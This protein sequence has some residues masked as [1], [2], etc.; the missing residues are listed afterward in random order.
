MN[1]FVKWAGGKHQILNELKSYLPKK[2]N[3]YYEP[4]I[5]G[6][7]LLFE[8]K[9]TQATINDYNPQL[10]NVYYQ[11]QDSPKL[12][13]ERISKMQNKYNKLKTLED[14]KDYYYKLRSQYN[15]LVAHP[16]KDPEGIETATLFIVLN[17]LGFNGLYR[18]NSNGE[19]NVPWNQKDKLNAYDENNISEI[20]KYLENVEILNGDFEEACKTAKK[21][22]LVYFDPPYDSDVETFTDYTKV[23]FGK[24]E[25]VRLAEC[26]KKLDKKGVKVMLS[27]HN[28]KLINE[29]YKDY[30][31][32]V[33]EA[34]RNINSNGTGRGKVEE[35]IITNYEN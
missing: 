31:I 1:P 16:E 2:Y 13:I 33:I 4:F 28:T 20:N 5:G 9:P 3:H 6:G 12:L 8:L 25:Q 29:L 17:K 26:F 27:N 19:F 14:K 32:H 21:D 24:D 35:V 7:A 23:G 22:D 10:I 18:V 11:I 30:N 34:R 15:E